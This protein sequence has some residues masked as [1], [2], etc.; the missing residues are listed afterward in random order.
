MKNHCYDVGDL[1]HSMPCHFSTIN[2]QF[3]QRS[4]TES[5]LWLKAFGYVYFA[6][7]LIQFCLSWR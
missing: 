3:D 5:F 1:E 2:F 4:L 7:L 6:E